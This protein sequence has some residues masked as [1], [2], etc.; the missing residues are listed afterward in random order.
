[1][2]AVQLD[3]DACK[4]DFQIIKRVGVCV[5]VCFQIT[6]VIRDLHSFPDCSHFQWVLGCVRWL[7]SGLTKSKVKLKSCISLNILAVLVSQKNLKS[8]MFHTVHKLTEG[9]MSPT[10]ISLSSFVKSC[11]KVSMFASVM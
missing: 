3:G 8:I 10:N 4:R 5:G 11:N 6:P 1:M 9:D 2:Q 7:Q